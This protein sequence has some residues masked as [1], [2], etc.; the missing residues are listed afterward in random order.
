MRRRGI[1]ILLAT[2]I[3]VGAAFGL[4]GRDCELGGA[5]AGAHRTCD[6]LGAERLI[7]DRTAADGPRHSVCHGIVLSTTCFRHREGPQVDCTGLEF[8]PTP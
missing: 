7:S 3:V 6:C 8:G 4:L 1:V 2:L 5:M